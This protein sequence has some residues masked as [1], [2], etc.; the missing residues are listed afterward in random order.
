MSFEEFV[1]TT[2]PGIDKKLMERLKEWNID[3]KN[4]YQADKIFIKKENKQA[5]I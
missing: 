3:Y 4:V 1:K 5:K 2:Y